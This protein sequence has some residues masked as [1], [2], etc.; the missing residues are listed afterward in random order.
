MNAF[1]STLSAQ[2]LPSVG[3]ID[4]LLIPKGNGPNLLLLIHASPSLSAARQSSLSSPSPLFGRWLSVAI[5][6]SRWPPAARATCTIRMAAGGVGWGACS[7]N[8]GYA[9]VIL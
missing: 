9:G 8:I 2:L 1:L 7:L 5:S 4:L 3:E 6:T